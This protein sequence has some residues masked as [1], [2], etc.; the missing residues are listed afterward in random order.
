MLR[1]ISDSV[2]DYLILSG[3]IDTIK[4]SVRQDNINVELGPINQIKK[5][6]EE[7]HRSTVWKKRYKMQL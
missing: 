1:R 4:A 6:H 2:L 5:K 7:K 3:L